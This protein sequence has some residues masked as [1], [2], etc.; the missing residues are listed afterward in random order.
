MLRISLSQL[1]KPPK[2]KIGWPWTEESLRLPDL[3]QAGDIW[4]CV[5]VITPSFNQAQF[6]EETIR[7]ILLQGYPN[8]EYLIID[9][10]STDGSLEIIKKYAPWLSYWVSEKDNGQS[11]AINKGLRLASGDF[12][13]WI[14]SDDVLAKNALYEHASRIGFA[15]RTVYVGDCFYI[16]K[17]SKVVSVHTGRVRCLEDLVRIPTVWNARGH[18]VQPEV[19]FPRELALSVGGV[20]PD[21]HFTMDYEL[22]GKLFIV[23]ARFQ[24]TGIAFGMFREHSE[25]KIHDPL[26]TIESLLETATKLIRTAPCFSVQTREELLADLDKYRDKYRADY[27]RSTG[28]LARIGLPRTLV[29]LIRSFRRFLKKQY[30]STTAHGCYSILR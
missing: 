5:T 14:N 21:N 17:T 19:L 16:D 8:L 6:L 30:S 10:G 29:V 12:A 7:S 27:W 1:P 20:N 4:P 3:S 25:Q 13:T 26:R 9:G 23:G 22:W 28:R 15:E 11:E 18:I 2:G 24:Y